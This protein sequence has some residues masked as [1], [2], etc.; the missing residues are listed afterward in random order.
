MNVIDEIFGQGK[1]LTIGQMSARA[2]V[3]FIV[4]LILIKIA[5]KRSFGMQMP[6]DN[7]IVILLGAILSRAVVGASPFVPI[8]AAS[9][10]IVILHRICAWTGIY[11]KWFGKFIKGEIKI[12]YQNGQLNEKNMRQALISYD[13]LIEG[14]RLTANIERLDQAEIIYL[15]RNGKISVVKKSI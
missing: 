3:I 1:E 7:I 4:G 2:V 12:L 10:V 6:F 11:S 14:I 13:D 8:V 15:E 9:L 5:G